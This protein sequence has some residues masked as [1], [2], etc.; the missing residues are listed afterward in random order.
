M[1]TVELLTIERWSRS[2][3]QLAI[4][5]RADDLA[6]TTS[7]W[8]SDVDLLA[9][10]ARFGR[11]LLEKVYGHIAAFEA[12]KVASLRPARFDLGPFAHLWTAEL[13]ALW[14]TVFR[15]VWA[16]WRYEHDLPDYDGPRFIRGRGGPAV[17][18]A[19]RPD[20]GDVD[21][22]T[23]CGGGKDSLVAMK[24]LERGGVPFASYG[25]SHSIYGAAAPQ[26]AL[27]DRLLDHA[28][29]VRRH[30]QWVYDDFLDAPVVAL[31]PQ[32]GLRS[33]TAAETPA[34]LFGAIPIALA[35]G[36][37][38]LA[39]AH[40]RS[41][42]VGNLIWDRTGEDVNHQWGKSYEAER[43]LADY[44][45][46]ELVD[47][48]YVSLLQPVHD[49]VIFQLLTRDLAAVHATHSCNLAKPWCRRCPKCA[50]VWLGY[51]AYLPRSVVDA[52]FGENLLDVPANQVWF[53]QM[54]GLEAHTPFECIGQ[55]DEVRLAFELCRRKGIGGAAM[56]LYTA[57]VPAPDLAAIADRYLTVA[58]VPTLPAAIAAAIVPQLEDAAAAARRVIAG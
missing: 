22:L 27:L 40:E 38:V 53:R 29:P 5:F 51:M 8:W 56:E 46:A 21:T 55:I 24:L 49:P 13:E 35:G 3:H 19:R 30:R 15:R 39:L 16:Q 20:G 11:P 36:Y 26:H 23:F 6:F 17:A 28:A 45:R 31:E 4:T 14:R 43:L 58:E 12:N 1:N 10:E 25:Y 47:V 33:V 7:L 48:D 44:V 2:A 9:L 50:Y 52:M 34:S 18:A 57:Q 42:N 54:L 41:A 32:L 37:R